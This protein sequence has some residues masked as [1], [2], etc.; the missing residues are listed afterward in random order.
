MEIDVPRDR[1]GDFEPE[2]V[3]KR[4]RRLPGFD[5]KV[6]SLYAKGMSVSDIQIQ[7]KELYGGAEM[8]AALM[9]QITDE[10]LED[11][12]AWQNRPLD[13]GVG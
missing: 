5:H 9:S 4:A 8:S 11:V 7:L 10:V 12:M 1:N 3:P 2:L 6:I 13:A